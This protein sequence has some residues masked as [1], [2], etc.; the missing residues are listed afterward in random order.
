MDGGRDSGGPSGSGRP[1]T[2]MALMFPLLLLLLLLA[3]LLP[4]TDTLLV[5]PRE[6]ESYKECLLSGSLLPRMT[7]SLSLSFLVSLGG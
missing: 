7:A 2:F 5:R 1:L 3:L 4:F 6:A